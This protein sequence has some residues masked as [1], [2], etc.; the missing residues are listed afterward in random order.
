MKQYFEDYSAQDRKW[1]YDLSVKVY[2]LVGADA[3]IEFA[4]RLAPRE[5]HTTCEPCEMLTPTLDHACLVC[6]SQKE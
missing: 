6:G 5:V 4:Q 3:V 2:D 1:I